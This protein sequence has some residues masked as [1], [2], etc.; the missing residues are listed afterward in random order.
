MRGNRSCPRH[1][2][3][4]VQLQAGRTDQLAM[5][6]PSMSRRRILRVVAMVMLLTLSSRAAFSHI[7]A[8]HEAMTRA[9]VDRAQLFAR[10]TPSPREIL[11]HGQPLAN[12]ADLIADHF[13]DLWGGEYSELTSFCC[14]GEL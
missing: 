8:V 10:S 11:W 5:H 3:K 2:S 14:G 6:T 7:V 1:Y 13:Y 9:A 12:P 4:W